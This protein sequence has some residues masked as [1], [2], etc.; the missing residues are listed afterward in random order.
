MTDRTITERSG[1]Y[2]Q[3]LIRERGMKR[4]EVIVPSALAADV[5]R[6]ARSL[7]QASEVR[8]RRDEPNAEAVNDRAKLIYGH[9][10]ARRLRENPHL[11]DAAKDV[12][13]VWLARTEAPEAQAWRRIL[14][15]G[16]DDTR[17]V[18]TGRSRRDHELR[19]SAPFFVMPEF[20][21]TDIDSRR[22]L[23][24]LA[25]RGFAQS[26]ISITRSGP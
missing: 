4:V 20:A 21:I 3:K 7:Q 9:L 10:I 19:L 25:R 11:L 13:N 12:V 17:H 5:R 6:F 23:W 15:R 22:K 2:R 1:R 26:P 14:E 18:L 8:R 16:L 24:R